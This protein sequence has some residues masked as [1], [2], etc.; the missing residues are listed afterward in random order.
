MTTILEG[1]QLDVLQPE[2]ALKILTDTNLKVSTL[3]Q[4]AQ[5]HHHEQAAE[6]SV[7]LSRTVEHMQCF[8]H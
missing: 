4:V 3:I 7:H 6:N 5:Q 8:H 1:K 2:V